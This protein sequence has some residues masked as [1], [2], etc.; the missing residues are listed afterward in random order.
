MA[1]HPLAVIQ[2]TDPV[3]FDH[4]SQA[5]RFVFTDG[6]LALVL[7]SLLLGKPFRVGLSFSYVGSLLFLAV[8][9]SIFAFGAYLRLVG[10]I[11]V[12][13]AAYVM[14]L[15]PI[16]ALL[17]STVFEDYRWPL[18]AFFGLLCIVIGNLLIMKK[19][20]GR[21]RKPAPEEILDR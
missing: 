10:K 20:A 3:F 18:A 4:L 19:T 8:F 14:L 12:D 5:H 6:A 21:R 16:I 17:L 7:V 15:T 2:E 11:G 13:K 1:E 9:G